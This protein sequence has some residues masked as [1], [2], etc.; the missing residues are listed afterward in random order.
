[1]GTIAYERAL[2]HE[3]GERIHGFIM[4]QV[5]SVAEQ[6]LIAVKLTHDSTGV[7]YLHLTREDTNILFSVQFCTTPADSTGSTHS[8][9]FSPV[10]LSEVPM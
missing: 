7:K 9:A 4:N 8:G 1:M 10:W 5:T 6:S 3:V 2:E